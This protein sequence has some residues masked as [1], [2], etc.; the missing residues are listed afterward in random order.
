ISIIESLERSHMARYQLLIFLLKT[1][2]KN[3]SYPESLTGNLVLVRRADTAKRRTDLGCPLGLFGSRVEQSVG[4][5]NQGRFFRNRKIVFQIQVV[6]FETLYLFPENDW[7]QNHAVSDD[8]VDIA[9]ENPR[10]NLMQ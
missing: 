1:R 7:I 2:R 3:I 6:G 9:S 4:G 5:D 8:I 10:R